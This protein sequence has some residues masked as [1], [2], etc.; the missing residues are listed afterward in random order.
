MPSSVDML[1][2]SHQ[3]TLVA[4][5]QFK[6]QSEAQRTLQ[7]GSPPPSFEES[8]EPSPVEQ[9]GVFTSV[10]ETVAG[11]VGS[12]VGILQ[13]KAAEASAAEDEYLPFEVKEKTEDV[14]VETTHHTSSAAEGI[15]T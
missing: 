5:E 12:V 11:A 7:K 10:V 13:A 8:H 14:T 6:A 2:D 9:K 3:E 4:T 15:H 1:H